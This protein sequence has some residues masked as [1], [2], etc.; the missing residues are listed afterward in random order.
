METMT[1]CNKCGKTLDLFDKQ[2]R[3]V[4]RRKCGYGTKYD[5]MGIEL[6]LCCDCMEELITACKVSPVL[7]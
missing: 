3:F 7:E 4:F 5:G 2:E 1:I 6:N